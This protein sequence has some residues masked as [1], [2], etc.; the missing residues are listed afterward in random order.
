MFLALKIYS[1]S[2][3][4]FACVNCGYKKNAAVNTAKNIL[5]VELTAL[6]ENLKKANQTYKYIKLVKV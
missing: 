2:Q 6:A 1:Q 3:E 5:A 4:K